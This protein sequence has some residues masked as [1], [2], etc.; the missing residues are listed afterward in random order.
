VKGEKDGQF[1]ELIKVSK[2]G[3]PFY[4]TT[5]NANAAISTRANTMHNGGLLGLNIEGQGMTAHVWDGWLGTC[6][7]SGI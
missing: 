4:Y 1:F 3:Y 2:D 5:Y 6:N 7:A